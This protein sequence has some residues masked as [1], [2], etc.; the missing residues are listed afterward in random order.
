MER[1]TREK[2]LEALRALAGELESD[3]RLLLTRLPDDREVSWKLVEPYLVP[4]RELKAKYAFD[5]LWEASH[6]RA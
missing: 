1:L 3:A 5:D 2:I 4:G 6:G